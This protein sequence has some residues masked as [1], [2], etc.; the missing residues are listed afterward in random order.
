[1]SPS[2]ANCLTTLD[3][4]LLSP[5]RLDGKL[6]P[7]LGFNLDEEPIENLAE[8]R[9]LFFGEAASTF[10]KQARDALEHLG[11]TLASAVLGNLVKRGK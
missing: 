6:K 4:A 8:K 7:R 1:M 3:G 11:A 5:A 10:D 2:F 9:D